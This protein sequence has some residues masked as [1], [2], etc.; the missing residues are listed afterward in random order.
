MDVSRKLFRTNGFEF[1]FLEA[2]PEPIKFL[3]HLHTVFYRV[4]APMDERTSRL[5]SKIP[6]PYPR[7]LEP[8]EDHGNYVPDIHKAFANVV[9]VTAHPATTTV[10]VHVV[11]FTIFPISFS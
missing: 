10:E 11:N 2:T 4:N 5:L 3:A 6:I 9:A 7:R 8:H 1:P